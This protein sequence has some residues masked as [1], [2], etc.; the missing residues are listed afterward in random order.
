MVVCL[1]AGLS[2]Q[3]KPAVTPPPPTPPPPVMAPPRVPPPPPKELAP[4]T[5]PASADEAETELLKNPLFQILRD[6]D[7]EGYQIALGIMR[8]AAID[9]PA[10]G[11]VMAQSREIL[12][13]RFPRYVM[14]ASDNGVLEY[15]TTFVSTLEG[16]R[17]VSATECY[18][19]A[20]GQSLIT[21]G[22]QPSP[23]ARDAF[24]TTMTSVAL[25]LESN[26]GRQPMTFSEVDAPVRL[27]AIQEVLLKIATNGDRDLEIIAAERHEPKDHARSCEL[28]IALL[29]G[30]LAQPRAEAAQ[31]LR[32]IVFLST[33][34]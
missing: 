19:A 10:P 5:A 6:V 33:Q 9:K 16:L 8:K 12:S 1:A 13:T 7:P 3:K 20:S 30:I 15:Y 11:V 31:S 29:K 32:F 14:A 34:P 21:P 18:V 22:V 17:K 23:A 2:A 26:R 25:L 28:Q 27:K 24:I 4:S